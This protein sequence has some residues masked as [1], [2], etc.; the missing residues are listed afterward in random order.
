[1]TI[2]AHP[3]A[4]RRRW[5]SLALVP[6]AC[7]GCGGGPDPAPPVAVGVQPGVIREFR[8]DLTAGGTRSTARVW[9][10][11]EADGSRWSRTRFRADGRGGASET[12]THRYRSGGRWLV[13]RQI[14]ARFPSEL[15]QITA[16]A[17]QAVS[18]L[19]TDG[20]GIDVLTELARGPLAADVAGAPAGC[21]DRA[22][23]IV[24]VALSVLDPADA[25]EGTTV[26][27]A[28]S[29]EPTA[30]IRLCGPRP[31]LRRV[32][33]P[34]FAVRQ[35]GAPAVP[36]PA[37]EYLLTPLRPWR[38]TPALVSAIFDLAH[39][40]PRARVVRGPVAPSAGG[41]PAP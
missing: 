22:G 19:D 20:L 31:E 15:D 24:T 40:Y 17:P 16:P 13:D 35:Q 32:T 30:V 10:L 36:A 26:T 27:V 6:L 34:S 4:P 37:M 38:A 12:T 7:A 9:A 28:G 8:L 3:S 5:A 21:T 29:G 18:P 39:A 25:P 1:M 11:N 41:V 14:L 33:S 2:P 23:P